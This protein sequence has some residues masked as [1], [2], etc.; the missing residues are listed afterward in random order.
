MKHTAASR[1]ALEQ[2]EEAAVMAVDLVG[3][4][5][6]AQSLLEGAKLRAERP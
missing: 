6:L 2:V 3:P 4:T 5:A 1:D